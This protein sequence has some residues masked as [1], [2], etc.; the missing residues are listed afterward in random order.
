MISIIVPVYNTSDYLEVCLKSISAQTYKDIEIIVVD[1]GSTDNSLE[2]CNEW[3]NKDSR[4]KVIHQENGGSS[5]ARNRGIEEAAGEYLMFVDSDDFVSHDYV[6]KLY[7][8]LVKN[9]TDISFCNYRY[10]NVEGEETDNNNYT[11]YE[12]NDVFDGTDTL[13]LFENRA[14]KTFFDVM[15]NK[16]YKSELFEGV[17]FPEGVSVVEDIAVLPILYHKANR[18]SVISDKLYNYRFR[19]NSLSHNSFSEQKDLCIRV[20]M[21]EERL[22]RYREWGIKE[23]TLAHIIHLY[24]MYR[25][26]ESDNKKRL[27]ELQ[28][29]FRKVYFKGNYSK[30]VNR[31]RKIKFAV[32]AVSLG[33]YNKMVDLR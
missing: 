7:E 21:M 9:G 15:W 6:K 30:K 25:G 13:R 28:T 12:R 32:A 16:I 3:A 10:V 24:A 23:L 26:I 27:H 2:V 5:V 31:Y 1:D 33:L 11:V 29:E 14:Y 18:V 20:P 4:I 17:R 22:V 8:E 19:E